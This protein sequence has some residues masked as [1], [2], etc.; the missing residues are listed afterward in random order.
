MVTNNVISETDNTR[1]KR[2]VETANTEASK[3]VLQSTINGNTSTALVVEVE[4]IKKEATLSIHEPVQEVIE[5]LDDDDITE[6]TNKPISTRKIILPSG[7]Y[8]NETDM[9]CLNGSNWLTG[10]LISFYIEAIDHLYSRY[11]PNRRI[12][13]VD[14]DFWFNIELKRIQKVNKYFETI[15]NKDWKDAPAS[16]TRGML[17]ILV[18]PVNRNRHWTLVKVDLH[19]A[20]IE[21]FDSKQTRTRSA[22]KVICETL[23]NVIKWHGDKRNW[24]WKSVEGLPQQA[25]LWECGVFTIRFAEYIYGLCNMEQLHQWKDAQ[26]SLLQRDAIK[27]TLWTFNK[28]AIIKTD[29]TKKPENMLFQGTAKFKGL[30]ESQQEWNRH[31]HGSEKVRNLFKHDE[32]IMCTLRETAEIMGKRHPTPSFYDIQKFG[33]FQ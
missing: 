30:Q 25:N 20:H 27:Q 23:V 18:I 14:S 5:L 8:L 33:T 22:S 7:N 11:V 2:S 24:K 6:A 19:R 31:Y 26:W 17:P 16:E 10:T 13:C 15:R 12:M 32:T 28:D 4:T 3:Q 29:E 9:E 1:G 21:H